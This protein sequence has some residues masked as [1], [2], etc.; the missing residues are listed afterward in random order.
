MRF[1]DEGCRNGR[2]RDHGPIPGSEAGG[3]IPGKRVVH[4]PAW[5]VPHHK[6]DPWWRPDLRT[7]AL[8][9]TIQ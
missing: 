7:F 8:Q 5:K 2:K 9:S 3:G 6:T 1:D 4:D